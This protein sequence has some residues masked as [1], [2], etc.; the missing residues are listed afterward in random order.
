MTTETAAD[1]TPFVFEIREERFADLADRLDK[2][3]RRARKCKLPAPAFEVIWEA[4]EKK[5]RH[6]VNSRGERVAVEYWVRYLYVTVEGMKPTLA[7][8]DFVATI[9]HTEELNV[10]KAVPGAGEIP[11]P[12]RTAKPVCEHCN[13]SRHR[14]ETFVVRRQDDPSVT[15]QIGRNCLADFFPG[16]DPAEVAQQLAWWT[17]AAELLGEGSG[18]EG[19][20]GRRGGE[21][22]GLEGVLLTAQACIEAFGWTS[23]TKA[24]ESQDTATADYVIL[25]YL[26]ENRLSTQD[27]EAVAKIREHYDAETHAPTVA[28]ALEWVRAFDP[29]AVEDYLYNLHV[30][31]LGETV[32]GDRLGLLCSLLPAYRRFLDGE[33][34]KKE[35]AEREP[36]EFVGTLSQR[37]LFQGCLLKYVSEPYASDWG[38]TTRLVFEQGPNVIIWWAG[39]PGDFE[40]GQTYDLVA[41]PKKHEEYTNQR[42]QV[43]TKQTVVNRVAVATENDVKK[44][45]RKARVKAAA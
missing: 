20:G 45:T 12:Y 27:K 35:A 38:T 36:S 30:V 9:D 7:G 23:R 3:V 21:R 2:M 42:T 41:T 18:D 8:W 13:R 6:D 26:P 24:R 43:V 37:G 33:R 32:R 17:E 40:V 39:N 25:P 11:V 29:E 19:C 16:L 10:I 1:R 28:A 44:Y 34:A 4:D 31:C 5:V 22:Y 15:K 14:S